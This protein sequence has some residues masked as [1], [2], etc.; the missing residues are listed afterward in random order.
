MTPVNPLN[1][2]G[3]V[4]AHRLTSVSSPLVGDEGGVLGPVGGARGRQRFGRQ[5]HEDDVRTG[6]GVLQVLVDQF[7]SERHLLA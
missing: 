7:L 3:V 6:H 1:Q 5:Q 4:T 2:S